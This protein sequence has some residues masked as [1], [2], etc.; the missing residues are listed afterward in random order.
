MIKLGVK[1]Q[2]LGCNETNTSLKIKH[3]FM[4]QTNESWK[5]PYKGTF[6]FCTSLYTRHL[7]LR[8]ERRFLP[9]KLTAS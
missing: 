7:I 8:T 6:L 1:Y 4:T 9:D 2:R 3:T 5:N